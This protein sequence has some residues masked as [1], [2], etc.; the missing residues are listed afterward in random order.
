MEQRGDSV[1]RG[2]K[3]FLACLLCLPCGM[4]EA[5]YMQ[6]A[7]MEMTM[8]SYVTGSSQPGQNRSEST[9]YFNDGFGR[10]TEFHMTKEQQLMTLTIRQNMNVVWQGHTETDNSYFSVHREER[11][12]QVYFLI[13][14]GS[15]QYKAAVDKEDHWSVTAYQEKEEAERLLLKEE[16]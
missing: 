13:T 3:W 11:L 5:S 14:M 15:R 9:L 1:R 16:S 7:Y 4:T 10:L 12:G 6:T 8:N 2:M